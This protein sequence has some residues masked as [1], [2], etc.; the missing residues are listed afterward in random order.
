[1]LEAH[2]DRAIPGGNVCTYRSGHKKILKFLREVGYEEIRAN[3]LLRCRESSAPYP[4]TAYVSFGKCIIIKVLM[5]F[6]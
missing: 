6:N 4:L 1:M 3:Q 5:N 2:S